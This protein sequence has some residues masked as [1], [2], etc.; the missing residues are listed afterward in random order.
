MPRQQQSNRNPV[1]GKTIKAVD[2]F[3]GAGGLTHGLEKAGVDVGLGVDLDP[4]CEYPFSANNKAEFLLK[5]VEELTAEDFAPVFEG[6]DLTLLA[7]CAPCQPFSTYSQSWASPSD[8][9]WNLLRQFA[10]LVEEVKPDLVTMENVP[11]LE[12]QR[13]FHDFVAELEDEGFHVF[14]KV[15][16]CADYGVP[17][18][19]QRLVLLASKLGPIELIK[20]TR[21]PERYK[22]VREA[23]ESLPPLKAGE[24]CACD[25][26]HQAS[27]LSPLNLKRIRASKPGGSWKDWKDDL[28]ADCHKKG[29]GK[30]YPSVYG[31]MSW[32]EPSPTMTTQY[33]GFG[34]GR[35]GHPDQDRAISLRE[36]AILQSFPRNYKF[37]PKNAE[38]YFKVVGRLIGNAV[39]VK[40]GEAIG[41]SIVRHVAEHEEAQE[42]VA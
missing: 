27:A 21:K 3:C 28:V 7:G 33:Y 41:K 35:F 37:A 5:S 40:L 12:K 9:R 15:V 16:K 11:R 36:G 23:I 26:L 6:S 19:R 13:V 29:S 34:N 22:T 32:D 38:I 10:R 39:P 2:L 18:S 8:K 24:I 14:S 42:R 1:N 31:R 25:P 4:A 20:P 17:Q 30:T